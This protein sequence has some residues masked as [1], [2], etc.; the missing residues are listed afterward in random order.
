MK[1]AFCEK[2][3]CEECCCA[4]VKTLKRMRTTK[5]LSPRDTM[6]RGDIVFGWHKIPSRLIGEKVEDRIVERKLK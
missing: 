3:C 4:L 1:K 5:T 2:C 6:K